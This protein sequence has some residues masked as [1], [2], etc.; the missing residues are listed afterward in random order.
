MTRK[1][2]ILGLLAGMLIGPAVPTTRLV[3]AKGLT[4]FQVAATI[5]CIGSIA[6]SVTVGAELGQVIKIDAIENGAIVGLGFELAPDAGTYTGSVSGFDTSVLHEV[7]FQRITEGIVQ[8]QV[9]LFATDICGIAPEPVDTTPPDVT[10]AIDGTLGLLDWYVTDIN[11]KFTVV[12]LESPTTAVGCEP[13]VISNDTA[14][15]TRTCTATSAGGERAVSVTVRRD[16]TPPVITCVTGVPSFLVGQPGAVVDAKVTDAM[17]G[18]TTPILSASVDTAAPGAGSVSFATTDLAG[19]KASAVCEYLVV[20]PEVADGTPPV[21]NVAVVG[22]VGTNQWLVSD[23][24]VSWIITD[25]ESATHVDA[26]CVD[27][28]IIA[29]TPGSVESCTASSPGGVTKA[30]VVIRRDATPPTVTCAE[31][32]RFVVGQ[33]D[34]KITAVVT[35]ATSGPTT[36]ILSASVDTAAPGTGSVSFATADLAGNTTQKSCDYVVD[37]RRHRRHRPS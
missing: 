25:P 24:D 23:V 36:P 37:R 14:G 13:N 22:V 1:L 10:A 32:T 29:D 17:S 18:P 33:R 4:P 26:G 2:L 3:E 27:V 7:R 11:V 35:D 28:L 8:E 9:T 12:D 16:A 20:E 30:S 21:V 19:N 34:A 15:T 5:D 6:W 31:T